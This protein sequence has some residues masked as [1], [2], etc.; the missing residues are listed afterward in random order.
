M[1]SIVLKQLIR[2]VLFIK[3]RQ[4]NKMS[5]AQY[6]IYIPRVSGF[7]SREL[8]S[9][10]I[11]THI[12]IVESVDAVNIIDPKNTGTQD[13]DF[14]AYVYLSAF[15]PSEFAQ[16]VLACLE[17]NASFEFVLETDESWFLV[18]KMQSSAIQYSERTETI[19]IE[20]LSL[21]LNAQQTAIAKLESLV[22]TQ[23]Q[24]I[25]RMQ[26]TIHQMLVVDCNQTTAE[27]CKL[28]NYMVYGKCVSSRFLYDENDDG[29]SDEMLEESLHQDNIEE[30]PTSDRL[31]EAGEEYAQE[32]NRNSPSSLMDVS[33]TVI[34]VPDR[35]KNTAEL[36]GNN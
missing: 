17:T 31:R 1:F 8:V 4:L 15:Y 3:N 19:V 2:T 23:S 30:R 35:L 12:G 5:A 34:P 25:Y 29:T 20:E 27:I 32:S 9:R 36:C 33:A 24:E 28:S 7:Y 6:C 22:R 11:S 21:R 16:H 14:S 13:Y 26:N 10:I 18:K